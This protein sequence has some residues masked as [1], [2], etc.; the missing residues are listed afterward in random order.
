M[1]EELYKIFNSYVNNKSCDINKLFN[2]C[3]KYNKNDY[4][5]KICIKRDKIV[6]GP[7]S[8]YSVNDKTIWI[9]I[10]NIINEFN[11]KV[12]F[13][14][15]VDSYKLFYYTIFHSLLHEVE[16]SKQIYLL[17]KGKNDT[18]EK[19][20]LSATMLNI[21]E[22][23]RKKIIIWKEIYSNFYDYMLLERLAEFKS[24]CFMNNMF[25]DK[26]EYIK[27]KYFSIYKMKE[28]LINGYKIKNNSILSPTITIINKLQNRDF[29][30]TNNKYNNIKNTQLNA[31]YSNYDLKTRY[32]YGL[33]ITTSEYNY[34]K[35]DLNNTRD[36]LENKYKIILKQ[37]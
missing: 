19:E 10:N 11:N 37:M 12:Y 9:Y 14:E 8:Y 27:L 20:L 29:Y 15:S 28:T 35:K 31:I 30:D 2:I 32:L 22:K 21:N 25:K 6:M 36:I 3:L 24:Y 17:Q 7:L 33:P 23:D 16:H 1:E 26:K 4:L 13:E 5:K 34:L 18:L